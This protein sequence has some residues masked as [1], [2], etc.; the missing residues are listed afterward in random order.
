MIDA[1]EATTWLNAKT[2]EIRVRKE[3]E[4][5]SI[6]PDWE[7]LRWHDKSG[8]EL[9]NLMLKAFTNLAQSYDMGDILRTFLQVTEFRKAMCRWGHKQVIPIRWHWCENL[10]R[11]GI[12]AM[13][14]D[15]FR[16]VRHGAL[17]PEALPGAFAGLDR[18]GRRHPPH[19]HWRDEPDLGN[20]SSALWSIGS[21]PRSSSRWLHGGVMR[22]ILGA[23]I[24]LDAKAKKNE[25]REM[26]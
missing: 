1:S 25:A 4:R 18:C 17:P 24:D 15:R 7:A 14:A 10:Q 8:E 6:T 5:I 2:G 11:K 21:D 26:R 19:H 20:D 3:W 22:K 16:P 13:L 23:D 9:I 12:S